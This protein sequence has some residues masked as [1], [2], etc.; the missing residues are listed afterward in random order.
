MRLNGWQRIGIVLS[1]PVGTC[2]RSLQLAEFGQKLDEKNQGSIVGVAFL[3]KKFLSDG[4]KSA[5]EPWQ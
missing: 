3:L 5:D 4:W 1:I 2:S